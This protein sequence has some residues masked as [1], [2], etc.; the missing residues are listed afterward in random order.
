MTFCLKFDSMNYD[1]WGMRWSR[2]LRRYARSWKVASSSSDQVI[3][4]FV[5]I[6]LI[7]QAAPWHGDF[8]A[9]NRNEFQKIVQRVKRG[10]QVILIT[11]QPSVSLLSRQCRILNTSQ[12]HK[13]PRPVTGIALHYR[14]GVCFLWGTNWTVST[15]TSSQY[16]AVNCEP[17]VYTMWDH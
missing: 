1:F 2:R 4:F 14:D 12:P 9:S 8:L 15:V 3:E 7:L 10:R 5:S 13:T 6:W 17:T 16:L 11:F